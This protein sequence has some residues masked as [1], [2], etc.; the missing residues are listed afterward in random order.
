MIPARLPSFA[1]TFVHL[2]SGAAVAV[3]AGCASVGTPAA[4]TSELVLVPWTG[5]AAQSTVGDL[6]FNPKESYGVL[7]P[8]GQ[9]LVMQI[10]QGE[11]WFAWA[12]GLSTGASEIVFEGGLTSIQ[13]PDVVLISVAH[14]DG[15]ADSP[16]FGHVVHAEDG[17][18]MSVGSKKLRATWPGRG[19]AEESLVLELTVR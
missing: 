11:R 7:V 3:L 17:P 10:P 4:D 18:Q 2:T 1:R 12:R 9:S 5:P 14:L 13:G 15:S 19:D 6:D 8:A 16:F